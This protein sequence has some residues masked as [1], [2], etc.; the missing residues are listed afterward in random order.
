MR[1]L[2]RTGL[3]IETNTNTHARKQCSTTH[4][5]STRA[6]RPTVSR[7]R[8]EVAPPPASAATATIPTAAAATVVNSKYRPTADVIFSDI[9]SP[10]VM[11]YSRSASATSATSAAR[12]TA[13]GY[14]RRLVGRMRRR[15]RYSATRTSGC[16]SA[17]V[18]TQD[19]VMSDLHGRVTSEQS[20]VTRV[21][22]ASSA[23]S[24]CVPYTREKGRTSM[25]QTQIAIDCKRST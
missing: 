1:I 16:G 10:T 18:R 25:L 4:V 15:G 9:G 14:G 8:R 23:R 20:V 24:D 11:R 13:T 3:G 22:S 19:G 17:Q 2:S 21:F 6:R 12:G 5:P 7:Y